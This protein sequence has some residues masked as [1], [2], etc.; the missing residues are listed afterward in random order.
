MNSSRHAALGRRRKIRCLALLCIVIAPS[1]GWIPSG[2][3][4]ADP[5]YK[6][7]SGRIAF[8]VG[9]N[10]PFLKVSGSSSAIKGGGEANLAG[11]VATIRNLRFEVDPKTFK[12]GMSLRDQHMYEQVFTAADGSIPPFVLRADRFEARRNPTTSR[13]EGTFR[14]Q[15]TMRGVT[16]P[17]RF[18]ASAEQK[19]SGAMVSAEGVVITSTFGV[20]PIT[21]SGATVNDEVTVTVSNLWVEP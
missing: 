16:K 11:D 20:K 13:W 1:I 12:T 8:S 18:R 17:V 6:S 2:E 10:V 19:N 15:L 5:G 21:Y 7:K 9:S 4:R 3:L 14:A